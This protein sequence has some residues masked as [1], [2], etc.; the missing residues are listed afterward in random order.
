MPFRFFFFQGDVSSNLGGIARIEKGVVSSWRQRD[1]TIGWGDRSGSFF[2]KI[3]HSQD[4]TVAL[5]DCF[6]FFFSALRKRFVW[7]GVGA[8]SLLNF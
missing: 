1:V 5:L 4:M 3:S 2:Y 7:H 6:G 8:E